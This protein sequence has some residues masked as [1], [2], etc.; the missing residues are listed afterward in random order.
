MIDSGADCIDVIHQS[1]AI[2][3]ALKKFDERVLEDHLKS[4]VARDLKHNGLEKTTREI[5]E[6][7][8]KI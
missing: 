5:L 2:Q 8:Q 4:C 1:R 3:Q 6:A 7:F